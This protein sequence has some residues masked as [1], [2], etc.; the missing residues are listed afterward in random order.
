M[1]PRLVGILLAIA[2]ALAVVAL[3]IASRRDR[4]RSVGGDD[5]AVGADAE[6]EEA[7]A[8]VPVELYF[9]G[10]NGRLVGE[11]REV[12]G[13]SDPSRLASHIVEALLEGPQS[14]ASYRLFRTEVTIGKVYLGADGAVYVDPHSTAS[15]QPPSTGS[16]VELLAL[17]SL[18]NSVVENVPGARSMV[19]LWNGRQPRTFGGHVDTS[20]PLLPA[21]ELA[22]A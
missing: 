16:T 2:A 8:P 20:R 11:R 21:P 6:P 10:P 1:T 7:R 9:P 4:P 22:A 3:V 12:E 5:S 17:Y 18:V 13:S 14:E 15:P 19:V